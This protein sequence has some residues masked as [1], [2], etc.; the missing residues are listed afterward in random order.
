MGVGWLQSGFGVDAQ[1]LL[2]AIAVVSAVEPL[3]M[4]VAS[5]RLLQIDYSADHSG[6]VVSE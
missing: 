2:P 4:A 5:D 3:R 6:G 1:G